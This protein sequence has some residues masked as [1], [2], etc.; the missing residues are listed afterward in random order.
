MKSYKSIKSITLAD[1]HNVYEVIY[2]DLPTLSNVSYDDGSI[3]KNDLLLTKD[4]VLEDAEFR[5]VLGCSS[6]RSFWQLSDNLKRQVK[7]TMKRE[8][9][10]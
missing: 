6:V 2:H 8:L 7:K 4:A 10:I 1:K 9:L 5:N 3:E